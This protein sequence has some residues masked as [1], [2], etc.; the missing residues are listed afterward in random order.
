MA[1]QVGNGYTIN[2]TASLR[3]GTKAL[4]ELCSQ[5][6][7]STTNWFQLEVG[8]IDNNGFNSV[9]DR[10]LTFT[11]ED[12]RRVEVT[13]ITWKRAIGDVVNGDGERKWFPCHVYVEK[14]GRMEAFENHVNQKGD[15]WSRQPKS[16]KPLPGAA[17]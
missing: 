9:T 2:L 1:Q 17:A 12:D 8:P 5:G 3:A 14:D 4:E 6:H 15:P 10:S 13:V 16:D 11:L 7:T